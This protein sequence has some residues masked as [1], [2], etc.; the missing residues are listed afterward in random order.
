MCVRCVVGDSA[1]D[2]DGCVWVGGGI[3]CVSE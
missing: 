1:G 3:H 2:S